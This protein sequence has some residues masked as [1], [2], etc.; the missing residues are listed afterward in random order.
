M[1]G[2]GAYLRYSLELLAPSAL[3]SVLR[4]GHWLTRGV[5]SSLELWARGPWSPGIRPVL[6]GGG[7]SGLAGRGKQDSAK[8]GARA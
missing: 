1:L 4:E 6:G 5:M 3:L 7:G 2:L 8:V